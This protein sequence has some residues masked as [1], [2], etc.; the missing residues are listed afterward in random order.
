MQ[1]VAN[2]NMFVLHKHNPWKKISSS[3]L[4]GGAKGVVA[5]S[6]DSLGLLLLSPLQQTSY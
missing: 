2:N 1:K 6:L 4:N 5:K 3:L